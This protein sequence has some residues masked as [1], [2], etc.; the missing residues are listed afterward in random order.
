[1]K[2]F[3][4]FKKAISRLDK[5]Y[6]HI[7]VYDAL[8]YIFIA[9]L[10]YL[11]SYFLIKITPKE[12]PDIA[13]SITPQEALALQSY[14]KQLA[15]SLIGSFLLLALFLFILWN[16]FRFLIYSTILQKKF[17]FSK[18]GKF[19]VANLLLFLIF[20]IPF[21]FIARLTIGNV[22]TKAFFT[23]PSILFWLVV[24]IYFHFRYLTWIFFIETNRIWHSIKT[25][26]KIGFYKFGKFIPHH[27][28]ILLITLALSLISYL[29]NF[30][31]SLI[32]T[33]IIIL[34]SLFSMA[35]IRFYLVAVVKQ[36]S[37]P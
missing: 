31:P 28:I 24:L 27:F 36:I 6:F 37:K 21:L 2:A 32:K 3:K 4:L 19:V 15:L 1:M 8:F 26:F 22:Q 25:A 13:A 33:S 7:I 14:S 30:T 9:G 12:I 11:W 16:F 20:L 5:R 29:L 23:I 34:I 10:F 18:C 17:K 35:F